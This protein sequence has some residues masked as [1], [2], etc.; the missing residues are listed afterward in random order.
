MYK[1]DIYFHVNCLSHFVNLTQWPLYT[2]TPH[3]SAHQLV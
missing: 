1:L 3:V 2:N